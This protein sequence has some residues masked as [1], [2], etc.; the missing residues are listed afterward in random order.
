[1]RWN[2][3]KAGSI[4]HLERIKRAIYLHIRDEKSI[5]SKNGAPTPPTPVVG[6]NPSWKS[7]LKAFERIAAVDFW[8]MPRETVR[9][10]KI[11]SALGPA[12]DSAA[13]I[14]KLIDAGVNIFRLNMSHAP[15]DWVR[16]L[17]AGIRDES[18]KRNR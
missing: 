8:A 6:K 17:F 12:T 14:G 2:G 3:S 1:L 10:T 7:R 5:A 15:H 11:V 16:R 13:M 4:E 9:H 18:K